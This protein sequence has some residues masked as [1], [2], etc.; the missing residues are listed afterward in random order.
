ML[1]ISAVGFGAQEYQ[2]RVLAVVNNADIERA[3]ALLLSFAERLRNGAPLP[4]YAQRKVSRMAPSVALR[5][6]RGLS[7]ALSQDQALEIWRISNA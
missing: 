7:P 4:P 5:A 1:G 3:R 2:S 6:K